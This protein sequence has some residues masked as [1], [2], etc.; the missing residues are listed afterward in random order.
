MKLLSRVLLFSITTLLVFSCKKNIA[1]IPQ[2]DD[3]ITANTTTNFFKVIGKNIVKDGNPILLKG[4]AFGNEVWSDKEV[5]NTHH[6]EADYIRVKNMNMNVIRFYINYKTFENDN[7]PYTYKQAG[8]DWINQNIAWAKQHGIYLILNMHVP[9]GG[10]QSQGNGDALWNNIEN[11]NRVTALWKAIANQYKDE[12]QIIGFGLVNE[13]VPTTSKQQ[14]QQLAQRIT[15]SIRKVDQQHILFVEKPIYIKNISGEDADLNFPIINDNNIAYEFH[16]YDPYL[17]THQLFSWSGLGDGGKYPDENIINYSN[18]VWYT[19]IFNN[20]KL[21]TANSNW[22]YYTGVKYK[23]TDPKTKLG[24]PALVGA[25]VSGRVYFD[26]VVI[27]EYDDNGTFV[28]DIAFNNT[29]NV[30]GWGYW[31]SNNTGSNGVATNTGQSNGKSIYIDGATGDC[32]MSNFSNI[33]QPKQNYSYEISGWMK[34]ENVAA[35]ANCLLRIDFYDTNDP[36][37]KRNKQYLD[38]IMSRYTTWAAQKNVP[39][40]MGEFGV[41]AP[42]FQNNKGGL[43]WVTDMIDIAKAKNINF[44]YHTYHEDSFGLYFGYGSLPDPSQVNQPLIDLL[45]NKLQ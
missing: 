39:L 19:A 16:I 23:I 5:P 42:C 33:F 9:Q 38:F 44:T 25:N 13:P 7:A 45:K 35:N 17:F 29:D 30:D 27:K 20:P 32:N 36:I 37:I 28:R 34:G 2:P 14:W 1:E 24:V 26:D 6:N 3:T 31:S 41:G 15:D 8:W 10:F 43:Q 40:Y 11:Q 22:N 12:S 18:L 4:V 21:P